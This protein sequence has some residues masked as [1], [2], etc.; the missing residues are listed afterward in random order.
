MFFPHQM[1]KYA[2]VKLNRI[3]C[4]F[5]SGTKMKNTLKQIHSKSL[6]PAP[7]II[8]ES[9]KNVYCI[10]IY[11]CHLDS[12]SPSARP[13][14]PYACSTADRGPI[15]SA[16]SFRERFVV[17]ASRVVGGHHMSVWV[18]LHSRRIRF[19]EEVR[20]NLLFARKH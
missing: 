20:I 5:G 19:R 13:L 18:G 6:K 9:K 1:V 17:L 15:E 7:S 2:L 4:L 14:C 8:K 12:M 3:I 10:Y 16:S 11:M